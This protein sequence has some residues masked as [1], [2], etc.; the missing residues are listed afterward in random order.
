MNNDLKI[1]EKKY[2]E[3]MSH[4]C[5]EYF[6]ILLEQEGLLSRLMEQNFEPN[7]ELYN[8]II[9]NNLELTFKKYIYSLVDVEKMIDLEIEKTPEELLNEAGYILYEC[10]SEKDIQK[11]K[12]YYAEREELCTFNGG[13]LNRCRVFFAV[14]KDVDNIKRENFDKPQRQDLY[15]TSV[16]SIQF[17]KDGTNTLSIKNRYNHKVN[18]PDATFSNNLDNIILGLTKSFEKFYGIKQKHQNSMLEIPGYVRANDGKYYKYNY[19]IHN[20]Y[21]CTDNVIIDNFKVKR[22]PKEQYILIDYFL[23]DLKSKKVFL[24]DEEIKDSFPSSFGKID[25]IEVLKTANGRKILMTQTNS[26]DKIEI[27]IDKE[28]KILKLYNDNLKEIGDAFLYWNESL[29]SFEAPNLKKVEYSFL[30]NNESLTSLVMPNLKKVGDYFLCRNKSLASFEA[31]NL[32]IVGNRFLFFNK[33]LTSLVMSNLKK[34]G[35]DFLFNNRSLTSFIAPN[36]KEVGNDFLYG[37]KILTSFEAPNLAVV[38]HNFQYYNESLISFEAPNLIKVGH[39]FLFYNNGLTKFIAP[40]LKEVG[41]NFLLYNYFLT[42]FIAPN[43]TKLG[44]SFLY[45]NKSLTSFKAPNLTIVGHSFLFFNE[46]LT[47]FEA[48]NLTKVGDHFLCHNESLTSFIAPNLIETGDDFLFYNK[49]LTRFEAPN[50]TTIGDNFLY[51]NK[52]LK[53]LETPNLKEVGIDF[54][55]SNENNL[56]EAENGKSKKLINN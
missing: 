53:S 33:S 3:K 52:S 24:Y 38:G 37:N 51:Y 17:T 11:F 9:E 23:V 44:Y 2:G 18:N 26:K 6:P 47:S 49:S 46:S 21:Y 55:C 34:V 27:E 12:K 30:Y 32:I 4:L 43:L 19:E 48:P 22:F 45:N 5:R 35:D 10:K 13:R 20:V 40:N 41:D 56:N 31:P 39:N 29:T 16:I 25:K 7:H 8:D 54:L 28:N 42:S 36:L 1:I 15:G 14:K 50:L